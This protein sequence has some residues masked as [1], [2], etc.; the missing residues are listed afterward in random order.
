MQPR[1]PTPLRF[2]EKDDIYAFD[3]GRRALVGNHLMCTD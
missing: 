1:E 3:H 2:E